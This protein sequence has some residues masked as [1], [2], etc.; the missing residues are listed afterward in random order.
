VFMCS[1]TVAESGH[2]KRPQVIPNALRSFQT[3]SGHS[4]RSEESR[5]TILVQRFLTLFGMTWSES[6]SE[7]Q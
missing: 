5:D 3:P 4:E 7:R 6:H 2:A 1:G